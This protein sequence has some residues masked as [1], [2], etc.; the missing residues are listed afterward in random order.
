MRISLIAAMD[1]NR[2]IGKDNK[3]P[4][5]KAPGDLK[6]FKELTTKKVVVMGRKTW[7]SI[8]S[9]TPPDK[10]VLPDRVKIVISTTMEPD[11]DKILIVDSL[12][13]A[14]YF[15]KS[16]IQKFNMPDEIMVI[17]G[18]KVYTEALPLASRLYITKVNGEFEGDTFF[19]EVDFSKWK[20]T[21]QQTFDTHEFNTYD[22]EQS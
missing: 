10:E 8:K 11:Q 16:M 20:L 1:K 9:M 6:R 18:G 15:A 21:E 5:W 13:F 3:L 12:E 4:P 17:G 2:V 14:I 7:E 22:K 19:P